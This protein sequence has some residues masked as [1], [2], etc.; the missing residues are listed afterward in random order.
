MTVPV[1]DRIA[2]PYTATGGE[3]VLAYDFRVLAASDLAVWR[4]RGGAD[5]RLALTTDYSV[6]G[7]GSVSG[8]T[9]V[10]A[11]AANAADLYI[12]EGARPAARTSDLAY[13]QSIPPT[14]LNGELDSL[15][16]QIVELGE[17]LDRA[18]VRSRFDGPAAPILELPPAEPNK[19]I[20][21][22]ADEN[23]T[24]TTGGGGGGGVPDPL[25]IDMGGTGGNSASEAR[26]NLELGTL[27]TLDSV[28]PEF[29]TGGSVLRFAGILPDMTRLTLQTGVPVT[30]ADI[31][32]VAQGYVTPLDS[33]SLV[34]LWNGTAWETVALTEQP[35]YATVIKSCAAS[36]LLLTGIDDTSSLIA[37]MVVDGDGIQAG[38]TIASVL[39]PT[40]V[41]LSL[42]ALAASTTSRTFK[43]PANS[44]VDV[45][46]KLVSGVAVPRFGP[47]WSNGQTRQSAMAKQNGVPVLSGDPTRR[48]VGTIRTTSIAG[49]LAD[50]RLQRFVSN[51]ANPVRRPVEVRES[52]SSWSYAVNAW[53]QVNARTAN[54]VEAV[55]CVPRPI[56]LAAT[57]V[58]SVSNVNAP[59]A[60][61]IGLNTAIADTLTLRKPGF[62]AVTGIPT[63]AEAYL[64]ATP[65]TGYH[66]MTWLERTFGG[67]TYTI[68]GTGAAAGLQPYM[69]TGMAGVIEA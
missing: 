59:F 31:T 28:G 19:V 8:G 20:G 45:C 50:S 15:Q 25:P 66:Y 37:G 18:L 4:R 62:S 67:L 41:Q 9:V 16:I 61:G 39:S 17:R 36:G 14:T 68:F 7:V 2:G 38:T 65:G 57:M 48:I 1:N 64:E 35:F 40:S 42:S 34:T 6:T 56:A 60:A 33:G 21:F 5:V 27:A 22:D 43:L 32:G 58:A 23:L 30:E 47:L 51:L 13:A 10:L 29:S 53:R 55:F 24:L 49:L 52:A 69:Q 46:L 12:V 11:L 3:T 54:Q 26:D 63:S 44:N